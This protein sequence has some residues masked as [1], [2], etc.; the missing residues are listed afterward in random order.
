MVVASL[1][2]MAFTVQG[3]IALSAHQLVFAT[4]LATL[5][6]PTLQSPSNGKVVNGASITNSWSGVVGAAKYEYESFNSSDTNTTPRFNA[7]YTTTSKTAVNV[8]DGTVFY[9]RVRA[10]GADGAS[11]SWSDLW[12]VIVD[13]SAP[14]APSNLSWVGSNGQGAQNGYTNIQKGTLSW[15][16]TTPSDVDHYIYKFW[17]NIPGYQDNPSNPWQDSYTYVKKTS[18]G[19]YVPTDF[20]N[21]EGTYY[22][23][24]VAVDAAGNA[25]ACTP[26]TVAYDHTPPM[27]TFTYS[28]NNGAALTNGDVTV[29][30]I[31]NEPA[32]TPTDWTRVDSTH[33]TRVYSH[34][35]KYQ[36]FVTDLAG[37]TSTAQKFQVKR[38]DRNAPTISGIA[39]GVVTAGSVNISIFDPKY[40]GAD[41]FD[42]NHGL[43]V[44]GATVKATNGLNKTYTY[45]ITSEGHHT[46]VA[47][48]KAGNATTLSFTI[49]MTAPT[50]TGISVDHSPTNQLHLGVSGTITDANLQDYTLSIF[51]ADQAAPVSPALN[52]SGNVNVDNG[53]LGA[54]DISQ[55]VDGQY[56]VRVWARDAAGNET[57][58]T[59]PIFIPFIIDRTAPKVT[60]LNFTRNA[61][62]TYTITGTTDDS[63]DVTVT[64]DDQTSLSTTPSNGAW[65]VTSGVLVDGK[66]SVVV[67]SADALGNQQ[68]TTSSF[69][70]SSGNSTVEKFAGAI[71][72]A[73]PARLFAT[74]PAGV[75]PAGPVSGDQSVLGDHTTVPSDKSIGSNGDNDSNGKAVKGDSTTRTQSGVPAFMGLAWYW[76][77]LIIAAILGL[78]RLIVARSRK[79]AE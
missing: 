44:D 18:D 59:S 31:T 66:H 50:V 24:V 33:F 13:S 51:K 73:A 49:D 57:G 67:T 3:L 60:I 79:S 46:V 45:I 68:S 58:T 15:K 72:A 29:T 35:G 52:V 41:G 38:I 19:G 70:T 21:K 74:A 12:K 30:M 64:I 20:A 61:N 34:N 37:N 54:F 27:A 76:W 23:C 22:F 63:S 11:S 71:A 77:L 65:V 16:D 28:N 10:I 69:T 1:V 40:E 56:W 62:G 14:A 48:D 36:V 78:W 75:T 47:T 2:A 26:L 43:T 7:V 42:K 9:W 39:E 6:T 32:Q 55:L 5:A 53:V 17:T 4:S 8:A 25:S